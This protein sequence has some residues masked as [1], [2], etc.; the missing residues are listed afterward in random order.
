VWRQLAQAYTLDPSRTV[1]SGYSMGG[2]ASYKLAF[3]HPDDFAGA[4]VLDGPVACGVEVYP[5]VTGAASQDPACADDGQS[6][7]FVANARWIPYVIDQT[8]ADELVPTTGVIAQAQAFDQ[9]N[10][11]Y[12]L[13]IHTGGDHL[14]YATEDRFGDAVAALGNP[15]RTTDPG[16][17]TYDWYPSLNSTTLG[18][19][20]TGDYWISALSARDSAAGTVAGIQADDGA[21]PDPAVT[22]DRFGPSLVTQPLPGTDTGLSWTLGARPAATR[23]MS[24]TL[25]DVAGL[26]VDTAAA[27]LPT[28]T[29]TVTTDGP[30]QL[31]LANLPA[32]TPVLV[33]GRQVTTAGSDGT[34]TVSLAAGTTAVTLG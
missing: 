19:G 2:W 29:V 9:L 34:V 20:A 21:L 15:T 16:A 23:T 28:G 4:L 24:L 8:Y 17:F 7:P 11:R 25:T 30:T 22:A 33:A 6:Q 5:G 32:G 3:E 18:I 26:T 13:F 14:V 31:G 10:Q 1:I 27:K 12:D